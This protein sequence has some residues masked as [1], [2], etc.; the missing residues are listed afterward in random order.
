ML[1][2]ANP[3]HSRGDCIGRNTPFILALIGAD[4]LCLER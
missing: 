2:R 3:G 4:P 1:I